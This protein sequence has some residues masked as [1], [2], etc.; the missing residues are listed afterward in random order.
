MIAGESIRLPE[1]VVPETPVRWDEETSNEGRRSPRRRTLTAVRIL[2]GPELGSPLLATDLSADGAFLRT[3]TAVAPEVRLRL[4]LAIPTLP[5]PVVVTARAVRS[6]HEGIGV[7]FEEVSA[8]DRALLRSHAG[9]Y[10]M[11]EA[12]VRVQRALG[13]LIPGNL[14]P[15]GRRPEIEAVLQGVV[16]RGLPVTVLQPGRGFK[17]LSCRAVAFEPGTGRDGATLR[18]D[19]PLEFPRRVL[20][21]A[22]SDPPLS[23]ALEGI[24]LHG[25]E[26]TALLV[27]ERI[28][29]TER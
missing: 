27:P 29:L 7:R 25:G 6:T 14:L 1:T 10:E 21:L 9:F 15:L 16:D 3:P 5:K 11:D 26:E 17:P 22:F 4:S 18:L 13:D 2:E 19:L 23:Y 24:V 28:Y 8:R 20:Y 12:I